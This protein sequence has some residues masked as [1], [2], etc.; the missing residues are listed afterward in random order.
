MKLL[1]PAKLGEL[2][3][4]NRV[5]MAPLTRSRAN[6]DFGAPTHLHA[7]YYKQRS[8]AGLIISEGL[9]VSK[10]ATGYKNIPG[11]YT[12]KQ[13]EAWKP[14]TEM[15]HTHDG[16]IFAQLW[17]VGRLSHPSYLDGN[18]PVA[19]S[20]VN[21]NALISTKSGR[22][23]SVTPKSLTVDEIRNTVLD[24]RNAAQNAIKAGFDGVEIHS[25]NGYLFHQFF[26]NA[27]NMRTDQYGGS[28]ENKT[29]FLFEV[30]DALK[31]ILP[32]DKIGLRLNPMMHEKYGIFVDKETT[33]TFDFIVT[34]LNEYSLAYVHIT[35]PW[36]IFDSPYFIED[37]IGHYR[38]LYRG[39]LIANGNYG[40]EDAE[41][42]IRTNRA[43]AIAFGRLFISNPDL[44]ARFAN[45]WPLTDPNPETFY[46]T[47]TKGYT[48]YCKYRA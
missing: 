9:P 46:T 34:R 40:F 14:V 11:I 23:K 19:P 43:D 3:L 47:G 28:I 36:Q 5:F 41:K 8:T 37:V 35:R 12:R 42:E 24:F 1:G 18:A 31:E 44:P 20:A 27:S 15:V 26:C 13:V 32:E 38:N 29:R 16:R 7:E 17:H 10:Q 39:F 2:L 22:A 25:S 4:K 33:E 6:N 45:H 30:I 21:P 48:D